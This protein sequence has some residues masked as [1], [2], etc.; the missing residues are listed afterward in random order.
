M[1]N[2]VSKRVCIAMLTINTLAGLAKESYAIWCI[3]GIVSVCLAHYA[4]QAYR[5]HKGIGPK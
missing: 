3:A 5:D 4:L 1:S 2:G